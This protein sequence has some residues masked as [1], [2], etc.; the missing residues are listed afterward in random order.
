MR[1]ASYLAILGVFAAIATPS[2]HAAKV[3]PAWV[4]PESLNVRSGPGTE[5][6]LIGSLSKG[7][8]VHVTAFSNNW[9]WAKLPDGR[10]GWIAEWLL[11]FSADKGRNLAE[12]AGL[13][14]GSSSSSSSSSS[15]PP[16]WIS[17]DTVNVRSGPGT[18]YDSRG[19]LNRGDK[20]FIVEKRSGWS[21]C[22]TPGGFGWI[23]DDLLDRN[24]DR[25]RA[26][27]GS[28]SGGSSS[29][30]AKGY[31]NGEGV[32]L[33]SGPGTNYEI[34]A[35]LVKGQTLYVTER[36]GE[37]MKVNVHGGG[38]GWIHSDLVKLEGSS[39]SGSSS[40]SRSSSTSSSAASAKGFVSGDRVHLRAGP[41]LNERIKAKVV[42]G[43]TVYI[44]ERS[45]DWYKV[46][47]HGGE[48]GW[49]HASLVKLAG[50]GA[51]GST[52]V[53]TPTPPARTTPS[54]PTQKIDDL[55]AWIGEDSVN[56]R[57]GPGTDHGVK[58]KLGKGTKV[59]VLELSGH[60]CKI[61]ASD[62][63]IGWVAG[64]VMNFKGPGEDPTATEGD[65]E[66]GVRTGW[67]AR[68]EVNLR[69]GPGT[70]HEKVAE[71]ALGTEVIIL[72]RQGDWYKV[73]LD[74]G[75]VGYMASWLLDTR[76]QRRVRQGIDGDG[77]APPPPSGFGDSVVATAK[78]YLGCR[79][80]R[81]GASPS[82]FDCSGFVH[83]VL[84][85][86]G[87]KVSRSSQ[88]QFRE[89]TPVSRDDLQ[90]GDVVFFKNTYRSGISHV[91]IYVGNNQFIHAANSRTNVR[92]ADLNSSYY[93][94]RYAGARRMR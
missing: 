88:T 29:S 68:P 65:T 8:K 57:Y 45:G 50:E 13:S 52:S 38:N 32:R 11:Q 36:R 39:G 82:G 87:I 26:Q 37:W 48:E 90:I 84:G 16:A 58:M 15:N 22:R 5:R 7:T 78:K 10:W 69:S 70:Q 44:T 6:D 14:S 2:A 42:A 4:I 35:R 74:N 75:K 79:Y 62:G 73:A 55:T 17:A 41:S 66:V 51:G 9:C 71:A 94:P 89:G 20:V 76:A 18:H 77:A 60:W 81:G 67:V 30:S 23:R 80:V 63:N 91:G 64:W 93:A 31:V 1:T 21:K 12:Q 46:T 24:A 49:I 43:Q 19:K 56:V 53:P 34:R 54:A 28:S 59:T 61:K 85:Q 83:F 25:G 3:Y 72:D 86:H 27:S 47:V 40:G 92:Y 33:R